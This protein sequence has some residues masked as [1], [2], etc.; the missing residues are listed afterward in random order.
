MIARGGEKLVIIV[1]ILMMVTVLVS[2]LISIALAVL[3]IIILVIFRDP[4]V[5]IESGII[6]PA[7]GKILNADK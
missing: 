5:P 1:M 7:D 2:Y 3:L 6:S 4:D